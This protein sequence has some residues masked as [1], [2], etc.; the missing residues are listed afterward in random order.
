MAKKI[1]IDTDPGV[2]DAQA[3][4]DFLDTKMRLAQ[5]N[6]LRAAASFGDVQRLGDRGP[7]PFWLSLFRAPEDNAWQSFIA[8]PRLPALLAK[9]ADVVDGETSGIVIYKAILVT[10]P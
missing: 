10:K 2:D 7:Q 1:I 6:L 5:R 3:L 4:N 8:D 9:N